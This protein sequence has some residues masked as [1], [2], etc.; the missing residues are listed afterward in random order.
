MAEKSPV[1]RILSREPEGAVARVW[2]SIESVY[3]SLGLM[4]GEA[5]Q[6]RR[7]VFGALLGSGIVY[8]VKPTVCFRADGTPRPWALLEPNAADKTALPWWMPGAAFGF[9]SGFMV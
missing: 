8:L 4:S 3:D 6:A 1:D 9:F 5:A 7:F 2:D